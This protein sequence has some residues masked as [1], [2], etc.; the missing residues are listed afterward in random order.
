MSIS[1]TIGIDEVVYSPIALS[2]SVVF[3]CP[4][5]QTEA[6]GQTQAQINAA[7]ATWLATASASGGCNGALSNNNTGAPPA[8]GGTTTVT[9]TYTS[10]CAP[11]TTTCQATFTVGASSLNA[12]LALVKTVNDN[13]PDPNQV[14]TFTLVV[15]NA[16]PGPATNFEVT[17]V[18]PAGMTYVVNSM[19]GPGTYVNGAPTTTGLK[20]QNLSL[21][22]GGSLE[23]TFQATVTAAGGAVIT[24]FAQVSASAEVDPDSSPNN[25]NVGED[26]GDSETVT[27][28]VPN[29]SVVL[30][31]PSDLSSACLTQSQLDAVYDAWLTSATVSG[32]CNGSLTNDSQGAPSICSATAVTRTYAWTYTDCEG[33]T[34]VWS[35]V[36]TILDNEPPMA[37]CSNSTVTFNG[38]QSITLNANDFVTATDNCGI[39]SIAL[40]PTAITCQQVGQQVPVTATVMD[41]NG[42]TAT[43]TSMITVGG[44]PCGWSQ[45]PDG[46]GCENGNSISF[47]TTTSVYTATSTGCFYGPPYTADET[48]L[49]QRTLC[50]NGS[51]TAL[52]TGITGSA[53]G[54]A[55]VVMRENNAAGAKKAQLMTNLSTHSRREFRTTTNGASQPQQFPSQDRYWLRITRVGN[56]FT[57]FVSPNGVN[58]YPAGAQNIVMGNCIQMGL[59]ATNYTAN[60]T[61]TATFS[62]VSFTGSSGTLALPGGGE[63]ALAPH[64]SPL[65]SRCIPTRRAAI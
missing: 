14:I 15:S 7:F 59:A 57:M 50:G 37:T 65:T 33:N 61:V 43:C 58:W 39:Q 12:D 19:T 24:N 35:F 31:C 38:Q 64:S 41:V 54:W 18:V 60:S 28:N 47:N 46:V 9:F 17:D 53:L 2:T 23:L 56:Q 1:R 27:V 6:T 26:D 42:N 25:G 45:N 20:W 55:G 22:S 21:P 11:L 29:P 32:G 5:N 34:A 40:N 62:N 51:I 63:A 13:T 30:T 3:N 16:G 36:Y 52:V 44:L 48:A 49:A 8:S 4:A 10:T